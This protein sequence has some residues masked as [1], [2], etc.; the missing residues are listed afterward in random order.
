MQ[1]IHR[2]AIREWTAPFELNAD[3]AHQLSA[4][5]SENSSVM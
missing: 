1:A 5:L 4:A 2:E 3:Q